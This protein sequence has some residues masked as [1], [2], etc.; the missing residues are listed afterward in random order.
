MYIHYDIKYE[1]Y[2][3]EFPGISYVIFNTLAPL[4]FLCFNSI[5]A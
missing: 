5:N 3:W 4:I 1:K 2:K